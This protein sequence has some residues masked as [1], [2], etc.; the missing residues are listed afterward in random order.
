MCVC[1]CVVFF[2]GGVDFIEG[3]R[4][5]MLMC[6]C[7]SVCVCMSKYIPGSF[8]ESTTSPHV[9]SHRKRAS[10]TASF[11]ERFLSRP[12]PMSCAMT[13][14]SV[15]E[16]SLIPWVFCRSARSCLCL[17]VCVCVCVCVFFWGGVSVCVCASRSRSEGRGPK[18]DKNIN[19]YTHRHT[20]TKSLPYL[21]GVGD[22]PVV[23][24]GHP[25]FAVCVWVCVQVG[26]P[27]MCRPP[28]V[29]DPEV[30]VLVAA[31][32]LAD[33]F[34]ACVVCRVCVCVCVCVYVRG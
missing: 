20:H 17:G 10:S 13:S 11:N 5:D 24:N 12:R 15:S 28:C 23:D 32:L 8:G 34:D 3:R 33:E 30:V 7:V 6:M 22:G 31:T 2:W 25:S 26:L 18:R 14:V 21:M 16:A 19:T 9:P 1:V 27:S 29:C 4:R